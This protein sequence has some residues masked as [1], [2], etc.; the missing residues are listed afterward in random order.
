[1]WSRKLKYFHFLLLVYAL[2]RGTTLSCW[3]SCSDMDL[4]EIDHA[5]GAG[6]Y[7]FD[8]S[9]D[10]HSQIPID[11]VGIPMI[12]YANLGRQYNPWFV[13]HLAL[14]CYTRWRG[15]RDPKQLARFRRLADWLVATGVLCDVGMKWLYHF[16][17]FGAP[18]PWYSGLSQAHGISVLIRA[19]YVFKEDSYAQAAQ[20]ATDLM[21]APLGVGGAAYMHPDGTISLEESPVTPP[22]S[23]LNGHLFSVFALREAGRFFEERR[24]DDVFDSAC[25]FVAARIDSYDL[26]YWSRYSFHRIPFGFP[27]I[28]SIHYHQVHIA[29]LRVLERISGNRTFGQAAERFEK[30]RQSSSTVRRALWTKR[31]AKILR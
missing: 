15:E 23:V 31:M 16:D 8:F 24:Y 14:G 9:Q 28:A 17:W 19:A 1:M 25:A 26:G 20:Q 27:D 2:R 6:S 13:G 10:D 11:E 21:I 3:K 22:T 5:L 29:Q 7:P 4:S 12:D 30:Y 18:S